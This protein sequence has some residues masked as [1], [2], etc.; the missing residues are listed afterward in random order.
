MASVSLGI[1]KILLLMGGHHLVS[2]LLTGCAIVWMILFW[3]EQSPLWLSKLLGV[4]IL[5]RFA[6]PIAVLTT[7]VI[8]KYTLASDY[9]DQQSSLDIAIQQIEENSPKGSMIGS[10]T[11]QPPPAEAKGFFA[12][13]KEWI[14]AHTPSFDSVYEPTKKKYEA[15]KKSAEQIPERIITLI[16]IFLL[17]TAIIPIGVLWALYKAARHFMVFRPATP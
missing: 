17:Q 5:V 8:F 14:A 16:A 2:G 15:V 10:S 4:F 6:I 12:N 3:R 7:D 11:V 13:P 1:Q 9:R